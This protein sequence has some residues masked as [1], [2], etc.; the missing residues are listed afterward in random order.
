MKEFNYRK[1]MLITAGVL[2]A[3]I[4][5]RAVLFFTAKPKVTFDYVAEYNRLSLPENYTPE[6][7]AAELYQKAFDAFIEMPETLIPLQHRA[8]LTAEEKN[9]IKNWLDSNAQAFDYFRQASQKPYYWIERFSAVSPPD[10]NVVS[11]SE[12]PMMSNI[13]DACIFDCEFKVITQQYDAAIENLLACYRAGMHK[14]RP[15]QHL[16]E[17]YAGCWLRTASLQIAFDLLDLHPVEG[18]ALESLQADLANLQAKVDCRFGTQLDKLFVRDAIQRNFV[19]S[20][21]GRGRWAWGNKSYS[22]LSEW[23]EK[24]Q[25]LIKH[26]HLCLLGPT[27]NEVVH[28]LDEVTRLSAEMMSMTPWEAENAPIDYTRRIKDIQGFNILLRHVGS[29]SVWQ[30]S[31]NTQSRLNALI[32]VVAVLRFQQDKGCCPESL[33]QLVDA[34]YLDSVPMDPYSNGPLVYRVTESGFTLYSVGEDFV[35]N[36]AVVTFNSGFSTPRRKVLEINRP[37]IVYWPV[38]REEDFPAPPADP[39]EMRNYGPFFF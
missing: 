1:A 9:V 36:S 39:N 31:H 15:N 18:R 22:P 13:S 8:D 4:V 6:D 32:T 29:G 17:M 34:G 35:D 16:S 2:T 38:Y 28:K 37:D 30:A 33:N 19:Y 20:R 27:Q 7:N 21:K 14:C 12:Y 10:L 3:L 11:F 24:C 25:R 5:V 23:P 26:L